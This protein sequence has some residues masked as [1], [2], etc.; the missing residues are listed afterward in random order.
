MDRATIP[1][2]RSAMS[3]LGP[4]MRLS[5]SCI[6]SSVL[7]TH[8][9]RYYVPC[10]GRM[11]EVFYGNLPFFPTLTCSKEKPHVRFYPV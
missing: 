4:S 2:V 9:E 3:G 10:A 1:G 5:Y 11:K 7:S 6:I 8:L